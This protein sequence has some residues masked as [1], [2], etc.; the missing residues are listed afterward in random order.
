MHPTH[1]VRTYVPFRT[2]AER[3]GDVSLKQNF[4]HKTIIFRPVTSPDQWLGAVKLR[5]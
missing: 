4:M 1:T 5:A 2:A 3:R